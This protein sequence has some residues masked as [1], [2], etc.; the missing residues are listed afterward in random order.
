MVKG[1]EL[2]I[3]CSSTVFLSFSSLPF[4]A[5]MRTARTNTT[6][7][8][9]WFRPGSV[10]TPTTNQPAV[11]PAAAW[12]TDSQASWAA[13]NTACAAHC[14]AGTCTRSL[15]TAAAGTAALGAPWRWGLY[16]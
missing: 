15:G 16:C 12:Q 4:S 14:A 6:T 1:R 2:I 9:W 3:C 11:P 8:T 7:A 5:Q 10:C 13:D